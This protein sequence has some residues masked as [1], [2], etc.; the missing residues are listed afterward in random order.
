MDASQWPIVIHSVEGVLTDQELEG[1]IDEATRVLARGGPHATVMDASR[2]GKVSAY[3]RARSVQ[4]QREHEALLRANC[5]AT[6]YVLTS[7]ILRFIAMTVVLVTRLPTP[8]RVF[9]TV[10]DAMTWS[11]ERLAAVRS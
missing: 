5:V 7:P 10:E 4:W 8:L 3:M 6:A 11:R 2:I 1:Y 9:G